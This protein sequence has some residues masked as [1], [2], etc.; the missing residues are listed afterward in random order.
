MLTTAEGEPAMMCEW[1][2]PLGDGEAEKLTA[3]LGRAGLSEEAPGVFVETV[4]VDDGTRVRGTVTVTGPAVEIDT[5][6]EARLHRL[7]GRVRE[8]FGD[9]TPDVDRRTPM[10]RVMDD[11]RLYDVSEPPAE[12]S[13][14]E[15]AALDEV[16]REHEQRWIDESIPALDGLTPREA[17]DHPTGRA[18]LEELLASFPV[19]AGGF[20]PDRL[21]ELLDLPPRSGG[22]AD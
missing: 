15:R 17:R 6:A 7:V 2:A 19:T 11:R 1:R 9:V 22:P 20:D 10:W 13:A 21:R 4:E 16:I 14:S 8:A 18:A 5:N 3:A 12:P